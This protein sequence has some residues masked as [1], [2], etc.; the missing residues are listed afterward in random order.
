MKR[1]QRTWVVKHSMGGELDGQGSVHFTEFQH[2]FWCG[3]Y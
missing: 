3:M 1:I 2:G